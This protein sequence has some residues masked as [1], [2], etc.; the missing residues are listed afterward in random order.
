MD[1]RRGMMTAKTILKSL[2]AIAF[3]SLLMVGPVNAQGRYPDKPVTVVVPF[4]AG[5]PSDALARSVAQQMTKSLGQQFIVENIGGAGGTIGLNKVVK[6]P[7]DGYTVAFGTNGTHVAN[8]ALYKKLPYDPQKDF[9]PIGLIGSAP[10]VLLVRSTL[11]VSNLKEFVKYVRANRTKMSYGS[12][13]TGSI[14]HAG[15]VMLLSAL[16]QDVIHVPYRGVGPAMNDLMGGQIDFMCDQTT[17]ALPQIAGGKIKAIAALSA[18]RVPQL[19]N[20]GTAADAGYTGINLRSWNALF[21]PRGTPAHIVTTLQNGLANALRNPDFIAQMQK[22]GVEVAS[23]NGAAPSAVSD[24][25]SHGLA[26]EVPE[27]KTRLEYLD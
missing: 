24:L 20:V 7:P 11:P 27:L 22:V 5:G 26:T 8:V 4:A 17:T 2:A 18:Q 14:S 10:L 6:A 3:P 13:G 23:G 16:K 21:V 19:P 1:K 9:V 25:I 15:C 12:A